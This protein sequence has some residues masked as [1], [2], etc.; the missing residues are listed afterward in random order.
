MTAWIAALDVSSLNCWPGRSSWCVVIMVVVVSLCSGN[1]LRNS[2]A[3][4]ASYT[5]PHTSAKNKKVGNKTS[6]SAESKVFSKKTPK[7]WKLVLE[8]EIFLIGYGHGLGYGVMSLSQI[9]AYAYVPTHWRTL[10]FAN[11]T[12]RFA[13]FHLVRKPDKRFAN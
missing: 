4:G 13:I 9:S 11:W 8:S 1:N 7:L 6:S 12:D 2:R 5:G 3:V 10:Q